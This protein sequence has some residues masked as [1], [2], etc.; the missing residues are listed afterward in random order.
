MRA[1]TKL[2]AFSGWLPIVSG[3]HPALSS[4]LLDDI[5]PPRFI[6]EPSRISCFFGRVCAANQ[7]CSPAKVSEALAQAPEAHDVLWRRLMEDSPSAT[8]SPHPARRVRWR[9][10]MAITRE[11]VGRTRSVLIS[12]TGNICL[13]PLTHR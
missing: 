7:T 5:Y 3:S 10:F 1:S 9:S 2:E 6:D 4:L 12:C 8:V 11:E 13:A